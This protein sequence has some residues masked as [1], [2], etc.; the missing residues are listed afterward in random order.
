MPQVEKELKVAWAVPITTR[1]GTLSKDS[2][3]VNAFV[4]IE[5][6]GKTIVKRPG[7]TYVTTQ[8][9]TPQGQLDESFI[10]VGTRIGFYIVNDT[11]Y[12]Y[13]GAP[14]VAI[15]FGV[16]GQ[17]Y[18][19]LAYSPN[20]NSTQNNGLLQYSALIPNPSK[21]FVYNG[22][23]TT[24]TAV[25][26]VN[27]PRYTVPGVALL[28][29]V[30]YVMDNLGVVHGSAINDPTTWPALDFVGGDGQLGGGAGLHRHLN[31]IVAFHLRGMQL[32]YD[33]NAAP[34]GQGIALA[35]VSN[36]SW[37]TGCVSAYTIV[38]MSDTMFFMG[39]DE[40][41]G[42][43]VQ[44]MSGLTLQKISTP[45][46][47]KILSTVPVST[48]STAT[49][50]NGWAFGLRSSGHQ[51][52][53]LTLPDINITLAYDLTTQLWSQWTSVVGGVEQ[54]FT[55]RYYLNG[56]SED[57]LQDV[58]TGKSMKISPTVYT[59]ATGNLPVTCITDNMEWG[60][61]NWKRFAAMFQFGDTVSTTVGVSFSDND[62]GTFSTP[63]TVDL[64]TSRKMLRNCGRSRRR[65]WKLT[66]T[67]NTPLRL[68]D[69]S[70][71]VAGLDG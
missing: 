59:D 48:T 32:Y 64:S 24:I 31:Y 47:E 1:D 35:P 40:L 26:D 65:A 46:I 21:L 58:S 5:P 69:M 13:D 16:S 4:E 6:E 2:K 9:G 19:T 10:G 54:Y 51:F 62:Y 30:F 20:N 42:R 27:Y 57:L 12:S 36:A 18:T 63:R 41:Y 56:N 14:S 17:T 38:E 71:L 44:M 61:K 28:D 34:N 45:Y 37:R 23:T 49:L 68:N 11:L 7:S 22:T 15:P 60:T 33:A 70:V 55:G 50:I 67:D 25:T 53:V 3:M 29:G 43:T 8:T 39:Q 66:H 52:Y